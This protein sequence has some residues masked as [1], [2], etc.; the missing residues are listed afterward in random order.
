MHG[1][2]KLQNWLPFTAEEVIAWGR[3]FIWSA[4]VRM[5]GMPIRGSDRLVDGKGSMHWG[6]FGIVPIMTAAGP[7]ISRSAAGRVNAEAVWLPSTFC[8]EDVSWSDCESEKLRV[9]FTA[10]SENAKLDLEID[11]QCRLGL[12]R[13]S[14]W[15]NPDGSGFRYEDFGAIVEG[16]STFEGYTIP[17]RLRIGW[18]IGT[19]RFETEGEFFRVTVTNAVF[20]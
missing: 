5:F 14:R 1:E 17:A 11:A 4:T 12:V 8:Q 3:G 18:Y 6:L 19:E 15:G 7:D 20:R 16:E 10:H 2:I 9:Q 13:M